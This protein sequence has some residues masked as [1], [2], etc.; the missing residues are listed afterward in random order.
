MGLAALS[1]TYASAFIRSGVPEVAVS[2]RVLPS[3]LPGLGLPDINRRDDDPPLMLVIVRGNF[4]AFADRLTW[5]EYDYHYIVYLFDLT[6]GISVMGGIS[7]DGNDLRALLNDPSLP[8]PGPYPVSTPWPTPMVSQPIC[9]TPR[10][11][12]PFDANPAIALPTRP[13]TA[14]ATLTPIIGP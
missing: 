6:V 1:S 11:S 7:A 4:H 10:P 14:T 13:P 5:I 3:E 12:R 9:P 2:R 8:D